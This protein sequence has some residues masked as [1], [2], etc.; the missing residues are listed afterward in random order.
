MAVDTNAAFLR[1]MP[2]QLGSSGG[3]G[4]AWRNMPLDGGGMRWWEDKI[5]GFA[6]ELS[7]CLVSVEKNLN[8]LWCNIYVATTSYCDCTDVMRRIRQEIHNR[9]T[10]VTV[11]HSA[12]GYPR[13]GT[14]AFESMSVKLKAGCAGGYKFKSAVLTVVSKLRDLSET[15]AMKITTSKRELRL[16]SPC[17]ERPSSGAY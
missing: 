7:D 12:H 9:D 5:Y 14:F 2:R 10:C 13:A 11:N 1:R 15:Q 16:S 6:T 3:E 4:P 8:T 17:F